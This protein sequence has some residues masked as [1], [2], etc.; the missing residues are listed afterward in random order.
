MSASSL[1]GG[2]F[3]GA[4]PAS[5]VR[6][7]DQAQNVVPVAAVAGDA[8]RRSVRMRDQRS[9][10][11]GANWYTALVV[12]IAEPRPVAVEVAAALVRLIEFSSLESA[13]DGETALPPS[14]AA[15]RNAMLFLIE[16][17]PGGPAPAVGPGLDGSIEMEW[18]FPGRPSVS[19]TFSTDGTAY[20]TTFTLER[21]LQE[22]Q[23]PA[24]AP[25]ADAVM[26]A[27]G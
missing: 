20:F 2:A 10:P 6:M 9:E 25:L 24:G 22:A 17:L 3:G 5:G 12:A 26:H 1:A 23:I 4:P 13:W 7:R 8:P 19:V 21:V 15:L 27:L 14:P 16:Q 11:A 18:E